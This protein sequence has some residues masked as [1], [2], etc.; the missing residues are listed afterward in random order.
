M[1]AT[2]WGAIWQS[3]LECQTIKLVREYGRRTVAFLDL[4]G[5][6]R[7]RFKLGRE[8]CQRMDWGIF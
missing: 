8:I 7:E 2:V 5:N 1:S 6:F 4:Y 3:D